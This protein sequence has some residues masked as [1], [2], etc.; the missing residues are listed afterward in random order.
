ME[1]KIQMFQR[2]G[3]W[4]GGAEPVH[5]GR[6]ARSGDLLT[7]VIRGNHKVSQTLTF[8]QMKFQRNSLEESHHLWLGADPSEPQVNGPCAV[9]C[10]PSALSSV[11]LSSSTPEQLFCSSVS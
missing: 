2:G 11:P 10:F 9:S 3:A 7:M 1:G 5:L 4:G 8:G 6:E